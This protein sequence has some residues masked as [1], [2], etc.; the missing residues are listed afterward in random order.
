MTQRA[1]GDVF[2][3]REDADWAMF[4]RG[5]QDAEPFAADAER[6]DDA[7]AGD[8]DPRLPIHGHEVPPQI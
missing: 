4:C 1:A 2:A 8:D 3:R 7:D 5:G 6:G